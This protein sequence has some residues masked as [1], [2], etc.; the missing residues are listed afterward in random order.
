MARIL[1]QMIIRIIDMLAPKVPK[2]QRVCYLGKLIQ[3]LLIKW[4]MNSIKEEEVYLHTILKHLLN[5]SN[6]VKIKKYQAFNYWKITMC[7]RK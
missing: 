2:V 3:P 5:K 6:K 1:V 4:E 7:L